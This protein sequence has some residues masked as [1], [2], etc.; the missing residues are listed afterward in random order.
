M[1]KYRCFCA[2]TLPLNFK[3]DVPHTPRIKLVVI[4][5]SHFFFPERFI[6]WRGRHSRGLEEQKAADS[7]ACKDSVHKQHLKKACNQQDAHGT[8][9]RLNKNAFLK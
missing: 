9:V 1:T 8:A 3:A 2:F 7:S 6:I 5:Q 4:Q